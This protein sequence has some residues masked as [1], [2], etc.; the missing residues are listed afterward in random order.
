[1]PAPINPNTT[2]ATIAAAEKKRLETLERK[3]AELRDAG[4][5]GIDLMVRALRALGWLPI[6]PEVMDD[7]HGRPAEYIA[8]V[9]ADQFAGGAPL[10]ECRMP[11]RRRIE[12]YTPADGH[13][14][15][16]LS[17]AIYS[18]LGHIEENTLRAGDYAHSPQWTVHL[19][20]VAPRPSLVPSHCG[21]VFDYDAVLGKTQ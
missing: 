7:L 17:A 21:M 18:C 11:V 16:N 12:I 20:S 10:P 14:F 13:A 15:G 4:P 1:M 2:A 5:A 6:P 3:A 19:T 9:V 8:S